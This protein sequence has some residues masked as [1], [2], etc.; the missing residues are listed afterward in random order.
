[1]KSVN[2]ALL[3]VASAMTLAAAAYAQPT[4]NADL[5]TIAP[6]AV[7]TG[8][9]TGIAPAQ[10]Q[11]IKFTIAG[12]T[13]TSGDYLDIDTNGGTLTGGDSMIGLYDNSGNRIATNDD[14]GPGA[15]SMLSFGA[16]TPSRPGLAA[17]GN[18]GSVGSTH[19][20]A[21]GA[22]LAAGTYWLAVTGFSATF[23]TT[24]WTITTSHTR[25]GDVAYRLAYVYTPP[26]NPV[27]SGGFSPAAVRSC[28]GGSVL[29]TVSVTPGA[30]PASTGIRVK[31]DFSSLGGASLQDMFDNGTNGDVTAGDNIY[32]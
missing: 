22:N 18:A 27:G 5:G 10:V 17:T 23:G 7:A 29:T 3:G 6:G 13:R 16:T 14:S 19:A 11:W 1:M 15:Y 12:V 28:D 30:N 4:P 24:G 25:S 26:G 9:L 32:S 2:R 8:T 21:N 20:G 31:G